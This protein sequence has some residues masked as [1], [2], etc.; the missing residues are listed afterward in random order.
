MLHRGTWVGHCGTADCCAPCSAVNL[1]FSSCHTERSRSVNRSIDPGGSSS[2]TRLFAAVSFPARYAAGGDTPQAGIMQKATRAAL[3]MTAGRCARGACGWRRS[4]LTE[5]VE[6]RGGVA[7]LLLRSTTL[8]IAIATDRSA[9]LLRGTT[10]SDRAASLRD[11]E[12]SC[13]ALNAFPTFA[14]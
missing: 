14:I 6:V 9:A 12:R 1:I 11:A 4:P 3:R 10:H 2:H 7:A 5:L 13:G 8:A